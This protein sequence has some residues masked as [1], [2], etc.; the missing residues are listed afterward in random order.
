MAAFY[1]LLISSLL[2]SACGPKSVPP[3]S[4]L[5]TAENHYQRGVA[6]LE[7]GDLWGAQ[8]EFERAGSLNSDFPGANTG[9]ALVAME[10]GDFWRARKEAEKA[11]HQDGNFID[12]HIAL[13]RIVTRE[14]QE[15]GDP[16]SKWLPEALRAYKKAAEKAPDNPAIY[17]HQGL[18]YLQALDFSRGRESFTRV[19]ELNRGDWVRKAMGMVEKI[20]MIERAS[21][22]TRVGMK[23][24]QVTQLTRAELAVLLIEE[25]KLNELIQKRRLPRAGTAFQ[26][27]QEHGNKPESQAKDLTGSWA[28]PW[29]E[30]VLNLK[31][32]GLE[33]FPDGTFQPDQPVTR[34]NFALVNQGLLTLLSGDASLATRYIGEESRFPDVRGDFFAYNAIA[35][36]TERGIMA[37]EKMSGHFR[38]H[39]PVSGAEALLIIRQLQNGFRMEF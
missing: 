4:L 19:I 15:R 35:L 29:V 21:P 9:N 24:A 23:I 14:G 31:V 26:S 1:L 5:D 36:S 2:I 20:Q 32:A 12:A 8:R 10:Q 22:G 6:L 17:Y 37:A 28:R 18:A 33:L 16:P 39:D 3:Q 30:E 27:P 11:I 34:A 13:G 25:L 38:P 7:Q